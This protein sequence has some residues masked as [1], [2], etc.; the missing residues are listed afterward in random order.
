MTSYYEDQSQKAPSLSLYPSR[1]RAQSGSSNT[2]EYPSSIAAKLD[3]LLPNNP[4]SLNHIK[5]P[6]TSILDSS[7]SSFYLSNKQRV[8]PMK[9]LYDASKPVI[10]LN[11][12]SPLNEADNSLILKDITAM[13]NTGGYHRLCGAPEG[14]GTAWDTLNIEAGGFGTV[15]GGNNNNNTLPAN[16]ATIS[17]NSNN[18]NNNNNSNNLYSNNNNPNNNN[19]SNHYGNNS[20][21]NICNNTNTPSQG[22]N[23]N[24]NSYG[25]N[26][27]TNLS[28]ANPI[29]MNNSKY[30]GSGNKAPDTSFS[31]TSKSTTAGFRPASDEAN[32]PGKRRASAGL[33]AAIKNLIKRAQAGAGAGDASMQTTVSF[34]GNMMPA[35]NDEDFLPQES[36]ILISEEENNLSFY[37]ETVES[38]KAKLSKQIDD[39]AK[40]LN[41]VVDELKG[42]VLEQVDNHFKEFVKKYEKFKEEVIEYKNV[43]LE[44]KN[45]NFAPQS[46]M[47]TTD[48]LFSAAHLASN[49]EL[50]LE[51]EA[52][53]QQN[54]MT[55]IFQYINSIQR[56]Q[57]N[58]ILDVSNQ[59][60]NQLSSLESLTNPENLQADLSEIKMGFNEITKI[61]LENLASYVQPLDYPCNNTTITQS[62]DG[63][64]STSKPPLSTVMNNQARQ[65]YPPKAG[66]RSPAFEKNARLSYTSENNA[67]AANIQMPIV[68][69]LKNKTEYPPRPSAQYD[70]NNNLDSSSTFNFPGSYKKATFA[71]P[72]GGPNMVSPLMRSNNRKNPL[73][74]GHGIFTPQKPNLADFGNSPFKRNASQLPPDNRYMTCRSMQ[75]VQSLGVSLS[76]YVRTD[77]EDAILCVLYIKDNIVATGK[78]NQNISNYVMNIEINNGS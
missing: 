1:K 72:P 22:N 46:L 20:H 23:V 10:K 41:R 50:L 60:L 3:N 56:E 54:H 74:P 63:N 37:K 17:S 32:G 31:S 61:K 33:S 67:P 34:Q 70:D 9:V 58:K 52:L 27:N 59:I 15:T 6:P 53:R 76:N 45:Q 26:Y 38:E 40:D 21:S 16:I 62:N 29:T 5:R 78:F 47:D 57:V 36:L 68:V 44:V 73:A 12:N 71:E 7:S 11:Y 35:P 24:G 77:H 14:R 18:N 28:I 30:V 19:Y 13:E 65:G 4:A 43:K 39:F 48:G 55:K 51:L 8:T 69:K 2:I 25:N 75:A 66:S 64:N 42:K 49:K